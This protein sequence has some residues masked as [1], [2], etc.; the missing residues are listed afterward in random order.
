MELPLEPSPA[1]EGLLMRAKQIAK[2]YNHDYLGTEHLFLAMGGDK[3]G[4]GEITARR[5]ISHNT[6]L[7]PDMIEHLRRFIKRSKCKLKKGARIRYTPRTLKVL[8]FASRLAVK[9]NHLRIGTGHLLFGLVREGDGFAARAIKKY[10]N[11]TQEQIEELVDRVHGISLLEQYQGGMYHTVTFFGE[12]FNI[13]VESN[14]VHS[15]PEITVF[16]ANVI[17]DGFVDTVGVF[18][19]VNDVEKFLLGMKTYAALRG[20]TFPVI[21]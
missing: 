19:S 5:I 7:F 3:S 11:V 2:E 15:N 1:L 20:E 4:V 18:T 13:K 10:W 6:T 16:N 8:H 12:K 17:R 21:E 14:C 9:N